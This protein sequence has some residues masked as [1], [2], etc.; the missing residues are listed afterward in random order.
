MLTEQG[1]KGLRKAVTYVVLIA[2]AIVVITNWSNFTSKFSFLTKKVGT[3]KVLKDADYETEK[4]VNAEVFETAN[5]KLAMITL[6]TERRV[7]NFR[8]ELN[9]EGIMWNAT[10]AFAGANGGEYTK[11]GSLFEKFGKEYG[12]PFMLKCKRQDDY[13]IQQ[14][15]LAI[16]AKE[17]LASNG[18]VT[19]KGSAFASFMGDNSE[20]YTEQTNKKI[21]AAVKDLG[22]KEGEIVLQSFV[23]PGYSYGEDK[24][25]AP[26]E[27]K[28]N[29]K[30]AL[31]QVVSCVKA[32]GD[33]NLWFKWGKD[34]G[35]LVNPDGSTF[36]YEALNFSYTDGFMLAA[37][38]WGTETG[39]RVVVKI[40]PKTGK[41]VKTGEVHHQKIMGVATWLP[42]DELAFNKAKKAGVDLISIYS[43]KDNA[44]QMPCVIVSINKFIEDHPEVIDAITEGTVRFGD[45]MKVHK[46]VFEFGMWA[47]FDVFKEHPAEYWSKYYHGVK[48]KTVNGYDV[49][50]GGT[51][52]CNLSDNLDAFGIGSNSR[53]T[54]KSSY[55]LFGGFI[56]DM[57]PDDMPNRWPYEKAVNTASLQRV[58]AKMSKTN[59]IT[60][61]SEVKFASGAIKDKVSERSY[62]IQ[63]ETNSAE[64]T[65][66]GI[67]SMESVYNDLNTHDMRLTLSG[68]TDN[69]GSDDTNIPLSKRRAETVKRWLQAKNS[70]S[71]PEKRFTEVRG[72][73]STKPLP[74]FDVNSKD[75]RDQN[76]R[77]EILV[78]Y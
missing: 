13:I 68:H 61:K 78:G 56:H 50:L 15:N 37:E 33:Q 22:F 65:P 54:F 43:T 31:G 34:N 41:T 69:T 51:R 46:E 38:A 71:F 63:F 75:G 60:Q 6:P 40:D 9:Y 64:L 77:V 10:A 66:A 1:K 4:N 30:L 14:G 53:G 59:E 25:M 39:D 23:I 19:D 74:G 20:I 27:W 11:Q 55:E 7:A 17:Y 8:M 67:R 49:T 12:T 21:F 26:A 32:D 72:F 42:G 76:R 35:V 52:V 28:D 5:Y 58:M 3:V 45:Q 57:F 48:E 29:P 16:F 62:S 2:I 47:M 70:A 24:A 36:C 73:G 18:K 44:H